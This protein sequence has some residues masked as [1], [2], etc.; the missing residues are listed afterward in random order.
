MID[1]VQILQ[2]FHLDGFNVGSGNLQ[3]LVAWKITVS[4]S[5]FLAAPNC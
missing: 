5:G 1:L 4:T 3:E 2:G